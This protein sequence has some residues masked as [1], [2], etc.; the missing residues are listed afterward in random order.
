MN[1]IPVTVVITAK[2][3]EA[4]I[5][6][7]LD[8]LHGFDQV[9]VVDSNS[10]DKTRKI[11]QEWGAEVV[12]YT[13]NG[14]YP[15]K[16]GWCLQQLHFRHLW[17]FWV[18]ADEYVTPALVRELRKL[19]QTPPA[20]AGYFVRGQ[21]LWADRALRHGMQNNKL[22]LFHREKLEFPIIDD[23]D[24]SGMGEIEG[25]Y[26][27]VLKAQACNDAIGRLKSAVLHDAYHNMEHWHA[28]HEHYAYWEAE[29]TRKKRWPTDPIKWREAAKTQLRAAYLRPEIMFVWSYVMKRGFLDGRAGLAF[30]KS[31]YLYAKMVRDKLRA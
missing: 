21:Y 3:E 24:I 30:A 25:H 22:C 16:R 29:M 12:E 4:R 28:R 11:A 31:R 2:N 27:P 8:A 13:W 15:K 17:V 6:R 1:K 26:Q 7:C 9:I 18:D 20:C 23:L 19:F 5:G 10:T 14:Q